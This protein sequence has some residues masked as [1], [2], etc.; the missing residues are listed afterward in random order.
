MRLKCLAF[1]VF[2]FVSCSLFGQKLNTI[3]G[4]V[5]SEDNT[6][7]MGATIEN[8]SMKAHAHSDLGGIFKIAYHQT[9]DTI[10]I[11]SLGYESR[12]I[13]VS[14]FVLDDTL[15]IRLR[16]KPVELMELV[17]GGKQRESL[18][19]FTAID[20]E[21]IKVNSSQELLT[22]VPGLFVS[23]HAGGG[24]AE[25][26][27]LRG[28]DI[29][30]GTDLAIS[31]DAMPVNGVSHAHGQGYTDLHFVIPETVKQI[32]FGK[33]GYEVTKG[34][35]STAGFVDYQSRD[36]LVNNQV[37]L[38]YGQFNTSRL[39]AGAN[40]MNTAR[41][42]LFIASELLFTD[43][44]YE[45]IQN[46]QRM[47]IMTKMTHQITP[48]DQLKLSLSHFNSS[49]DASGQIPQR[50]VSAG[51]ISRFGAVDDTEGGNTSRSNLILNYT[52][53][54]DDSTSWKSYFY[55]S[56]ADFDLYSNFTFFLRDSINGDQI[57]Q[58]E[59]RTTFGGGTEVKKE[60]NIQNKMLLTSHYGLS[61]RQDY[62]E[63][64][65]LNYT[66]SRNY[67]STENLA[68]ITES[69][70]GLFYGISLAFDK[71]KI[72]PGVRLD[73]FRFQLMD[74]LNVEYQTLVHSKAL[75]S[76]KL[77]FYYTPSALVQ[78]YLKSGKSFHSNDAR[79]SLDGGANDLLTSSYGA[80]F[81]TVIKPN[82]NM[83]VNLALW[84][85]Y[86]E[87]ELVYVGDEGIVE[88]SGRSY[89]SGFDASVRY[90]IAKW[91]Y[92]NFDVTYSHGKFLDESQEFE[93]IPLA[94]KWTAVN[95]V[96][97]SHGA[98]YYGLASR[99]LSERPANE[100]NSITAKGYLVHDAYLGFKKQRYCVEI[101][102]SNLLNS[103]WNEAQFATESRLQNESS[104]VEELHFTPGTPFFA[105]ALIK[106]NF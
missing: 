41:T 83:L 11:S 59:N 27:F 44:P 21:K 42:K 79:S 34:N 69:N 14:E 102:V 56:K 7:I 68:D 28:F 55:L 98:L 53:S 87:Q 50:L 64:V 30:H 73:F 97:C 9:K 39:F 75:L 86:L 105:Q 8:T 78:L 62:L 48:K 106:L 32:D 101:R 88:P 43:G 60:R 72:D 91:L 82:K 70:L 47:N 96:H 2:Y 54:L 40:F 94:P 5:L 13:V 104:S 49:W 19:F 12:K 100:D 99:L 92:W 15:I 51:Q 61:L 24:K 76:P 57:Q 3:T 16:P 81:G 63:D 26:V 89:R 58:K 38:A 18:D 33:G 84:N 85:L 1:T 93:H 35:F 77:N 23:Q 46:F 10:F 74:K 36:T 45:A 66:K 20:M 4:Q 52:K 25:Q 90:Q 67:L 17:I 37:K 29:D 95:G 22:L 103:E 71:I 65:T 31:I 80:D 6:I